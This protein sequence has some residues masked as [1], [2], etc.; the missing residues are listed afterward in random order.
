MGSERA[1]VGK[2]A[3]SPD[4]DAKRET[5]EA[6]IGSA[7]L[8][9]SL[10]CVK[11]IG[12]DGN[13]EFISELGRDLLEVSPDAVLIGQAWAALWP[14]ET[15]G[16]VIAALADAGAG[17]V[18][19]FDGFCPTARGT[20]K[21]WDVVVSPM[22]ATDGR[23]AAF[24]SVS[25]DIT[26]QKAIERALSAS[27]QRFRGLADNMAQLAWMADAH[28]DVFWYNKR[29]LDYAGVSLDE[30]R[31]A[32]WRKV[33]HPDYVDRVATRVAAAF[34]SRRMWEDIVPLRAADGSY[35]WFLTR[36]MPVPDDKGKISLWCATHTDITEQRR[37]GQRLRQ[38]ARVIELSHEA[39]LV[40]D[41]EH[42]I[43]LWN[44][45]CEELY[46]Y[47]RNEALGARSHDL[48]ATR[49][50]LGGE[51]FERDLRAN[52]E[53]A[54]ELLHRAK[55]GSEVW[56]DSRQELIR[57]E[58]RELVLESNRDITER[59]KANDLRELLVAEL[60]HRVKNSL[61]IVQSIAR[62]TAR[63]QHDLKM[64][65]T[66]FS[67]RLQALASAQTILSDAHWSGADLRHLVQSQILLTG[68][69]AS[70]IS[71]DG[72]DILLP[73]EI[74]LQ[75][76]LVVHELTANALQH[77]ALSRATGRVAIGLH[78]QDEA[79]TAAV[80][81]WRET[82]GPTV[83]PPGTPGFGRR[84]I[85]RTGKLP[86]LSTFLEYP[87]EGAHCRIS[88]ALQGSSGRG[89][90]YFHPAHQIVEGRLPEIRQRPPRMAGRRVLLIE[91]DPIDAL[92][93]E[94]A[95]AEAG[96]LVIGPVHLPE[97][98]DRLLAELAFDVAIVSIDP[99]IVLAETIIDRLT[100]AGK[101]VLRIPAKLD[102]QTATE[103]GVLL[104][105]VAPEQ[106]TAA[107]AELRSPDE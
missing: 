89:R 53:W 35:R 28:G 14:E 1:V 48:L 60:D 24:L 26:E 84:L 31:G 21:W 9:S 50:P 10:D 66:R 4:A 70:R 37:L 98:I 103:P 101:P 20:P 58:G 68:G 3:A 16:S 6:L 67:S 106:L 83:R 79:G 71:I 100:A 44:K 2:D 63:S 65:M 34:K 97:E 82:G 107:L 49:H 41:F 99:S 91:D 25:R 15:R 88:I 36:A 93:M 74:A 72:P 45:G 47:Q 94:E 73:P 86:A 23:I 85:E 39:I 62:E 95:L 13:L 33:H 5:I 43:V 81:D 12:L 77:G 27:E 40:W 30:M 17:K 46:Q 90:A 57:S 69:D 22:R 61:A 87:P 59:R 92:R 105:P 29:W 52:G 102:A 75:L 76:T 96:W 42:G 78:I 80:L 38:L 7:M 55:D 56:V 104:K 51:A 18:V 19:R 64:F 11:V 32:G 54:G 8:A